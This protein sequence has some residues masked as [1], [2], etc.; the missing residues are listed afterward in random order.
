MATASEA[1][2]PTAVPSRRRGL[3]GNPRVEQWIR[4]W[5]LLRRNS[6]AIVGLVILLLFVGLA[7]YGVFQ[8]LPWGTMNTFCSTN[9]GNG[10]A[11][12]C[13]PGQT[14]ICTYQIGTTPPHPGCFRTPI[15]Y[16]SVVPPTWGTAPVSIGPLPLGSLTVDPTGTLSYSIYQGLLR[17]ID[18]TLIISVSI[19][20]IGA[21][22]GLLLGAVSGY[23]GG[24]VD[25][26]IMRLV[27]IFLSIPQILF[28]IILVAVVETTTKSLFGLGSVDTDVLLL[29]IGFTAV[30]WPFYARIVRGQVLVTR[31]QKYVEAARASGA[32]RGRIIVRHIVP[33]SMY[34]VFI[35]MSLDVGTIP[36]FIAALAFLGFQLFPTLY[37]PEWG[38]IAANSVD[39]LPSF[40]E[41]CQVGI[42]D[43]PWW[44]IF[45]PGVALFLY[46]ISVN[47]L[48]DGIRD[49]LDPR[50]RR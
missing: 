30:W 11:S 37:F 21:S 43:L 42:C 14:A 20:A 4:T 16:P 19:V 33:N 39:Q 3:R 12:N 17:G 34:P 36:L 35:Q 29:I 10:G 18:W 50:L 41:A 22:A 28:V 38:V 31:E 44:Q 40:L 32:Q 15:G 49:A 8:P 9:Q 6:L 27:D 7:I 26:T 47:F 1:L 24:W 23:L 5:Y 45:I 2:E 48:A 25:E 46:A 13:L